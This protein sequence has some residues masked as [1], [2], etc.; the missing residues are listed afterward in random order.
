MD[1]NKMKRKILRLWKSGK[2][3]INRILEDTS[4]LIKDGEKHLKKVTKKTERNIEK[5]VL[6][7]KRKKLYYELGESIAKS[8][9]KKSKK[10]SKLMSQIKNIGNSIKKIR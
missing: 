9:G 1:K 10:T 8:G 2:K 4:L 6:S 3:D 7:L 5:L